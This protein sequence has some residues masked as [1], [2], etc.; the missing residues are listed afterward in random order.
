MEVKDERFVTAAEAKKT[1][2][3]KSREKEL[4]YEQKNALDFLKRFHKISES[5]RKKLT[6]DLENLKLKERHVALLIDCLP[7][8]IDELNL[9]FA[10]EIINISEDEKKKIVSLTKKFA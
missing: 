6:K 3:A 10:H 9:L 5:D 7:K 8:D 2:S 1:L 4:G